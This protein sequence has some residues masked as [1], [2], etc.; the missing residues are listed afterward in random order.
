MTRRRAPPPGGEGS[1]P[2]RVSLSVLCRPAPRLSPAA[3]RP[4][5]LATRLLL[6]S[7][8]RRAARAGLCAMR[9]RSGC[10]G[11]RG[12]KGKTGGGKVALASGQSAGASAASVPRW[13]ARPSPMSLAYLHSA[14]QRV[15]RVM[16][17]RQGPGGLQHVLELPLI[18]IPHRD[19]LSTRAWRQRM[20]G[21]APLLP[22]LPRAHS[23][24]PSSPHPPFTPS[25]PWVGGRRRASHRRRLR[26]PASRRRR[27]PCAR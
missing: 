9:R 23:T 26:R 15:H 8:P 5:H 3:P 20:R 11:E 12:R 7:W 10:A 21:R 19:T 22:P 16:E 17:T 24:T 13:T 25:R 18:I 4:R 6:A 14:G 1:S 2:G 27:R